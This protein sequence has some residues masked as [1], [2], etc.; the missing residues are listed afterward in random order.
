MAGLLNIGISGLQAF[1]NSLNTTGHN[2]A[3]VDTPGYS[4]Q[5][6]E[7]ATRIPFQTGI[8]YL[9]SGVKATNVRRMYDDFL[10]TQMRSTQSASSELAAYSSHAE[11]IDN[12][13]ANPEAGLDPALSS[14]FN[15]MH[16]LADDPASIPARQQLLAEASSMIDRFHGLSTQFNNMRTDLNKEMTSVVEEINTLAGAI[17]RVNQDIVIARGAGVNIEPNDLLDRREE[18][19]K[20]L[21]KRV[22]ISVVLQDNGAANVFIGKGQAI[23]MDSGSTRLD[24]TFATDDPRKLDVVL[25][26]ASNQVITS[27][28]AGGEFGGLLDFRDQIL[29]PGQNQLGLIAL[30]VTQS[31]N[32]QHQLGLDLNGTTGGLLFSAPETSNGVVLPDTLN[33]GSGSATLTFGNL[34]EITASEYELEFTGGTSYTLTRLSDNAVFN[35]DTTLPAT[36]TN[37]GFTLAMGGVPVVGDKI[38]IRPTRVAADMIS[39]NIVD[40]RRLAVTGPLRAVATAGNAGVAVLSNPNVSGATAPLIQP[41]ADITM[42]WNSGT[43]GFDVLPADGTVP[44]NFIAYNPINDS[45]SSI[46]IVG[47]TPD[48]VGNP[49]Y[50]YDL[51]FTPTGTPINGDSFV[52]QSNSTGGSVGVG[53]NR[54]ALAMAGIQNEKV[55]LGDSATIQRGYG[56]LISHVGSKTHQSQV[57]S[58][59]AGAL[60]ERNE[61]AL[62]SIAGVNLDEE[63]ANLVRFQQAY[64]ASAQVISVAGTLFDTLLSA[65]RR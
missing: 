3:N 27:Q 40:P 19:L 18:L 25:A 54:N 6:V 49:G 22:D 34:A 24:T 23:V 63:A 45:G 10:A 8:G 13:L 61:T 37:D 46:T 39:L 62:S 2:I 32:E 38:T 42:T 43:N 30:G 57:N 5:R 29:D 31:I 52:I 59:A 9:G 7:F 11:R 65:I 20:E 21:S 51:T 56:Q 17:A 33:V 15:A 1:Q 60:L 48:P 16:A 35:L 28:L 12:L 4:R 36:L 47:F 64:Q 50:S 58:K 55:L 41:P 14:F 53:D 26:S 44:T